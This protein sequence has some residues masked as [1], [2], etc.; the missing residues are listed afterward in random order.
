MGGGNDEWGQTRDRPSSDQSHV[1]E[2]DLHLAFGNAVFH[3][4]TVGVVVKRWFLGDLYIY[5][6]RVDGL[7]EDLYD[8]DYED[9]GQ[10]SHAAVLQIGWDDTIEG[11][12]AGNIFFDRVYF[13]RTFH[14]WTSFVF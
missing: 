10:N 5:Q 4:L 14:E 3:D 9:G 8:F 1:A 7:L 13:D 2:H 12:D 11:R 6:L